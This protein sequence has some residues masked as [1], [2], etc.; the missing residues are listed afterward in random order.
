MSVIF[1]PDAK[2][3]YNPIKATKIKTRYLFIFF[4]FFLFF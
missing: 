2:T 1:S 4:S 3:R